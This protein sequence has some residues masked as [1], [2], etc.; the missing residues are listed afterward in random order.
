VREWGN[1]L[2]SSVQKMSFLPEAH[3]DFIIAVILEETGII[4]LALIISFRQ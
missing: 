2:G 1:G 3:T 4:G